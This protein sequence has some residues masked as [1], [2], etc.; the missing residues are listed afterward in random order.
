MTATDT[1]M[2]ATD[3][4]SYLWPHG[5]DHFHRGIKFKLVPVRETVQSPWRLATTEFHVEEAKKV[6]TELW[7]IAMLEDG[8]VKGIQEQCC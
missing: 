1:G 5:S 2:T 8:T 6:I 3:I 7:T 4:G